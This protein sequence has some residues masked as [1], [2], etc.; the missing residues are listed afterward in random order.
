MT[1]GAP[2]PY[3]PPSEG[4]GGEGPGS[5]ARPPGGARPPR[6]RPPRALPLGV[7]VF[8]VLEI[9][10]LT[11]LADAT[12][13]LVVLAVQVA[14]V[15]LGAAVVKRAGRRAWHGLVETLEGL[16]PGTVPDAEARR[17]TAARSESG[18]G[19]H[20]LAMLGGLLLMVPG[21]LSDAVGLLCLFPP[22]ATLLRRG[23]ERRLLHRARRAA[24]GSFDDVLRQAR[25]AE[26]QA[27][28]HRPGGRIVQGEVVRDD[29][30]DTTEDGHPGGGGRPPR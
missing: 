20:G 2:Y 15:V 10:L 29:A 7:A 18:R 14:G 5:G 27:R 25:T 12:D 19:G 13:G 1:T 28:I 17:E 24:P 22:T 26:E 8:A 23:V 6:R 9:W 11:L 30:T 21:L 3:Q 16:Q 4:P